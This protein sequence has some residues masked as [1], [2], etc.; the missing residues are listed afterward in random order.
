MLSFTKSQPL[1]TVTYY[2]LTIHSIF[3]IF[4]SLDYSYTFYLSVFITIFKYSTIYAGKS[5]VC[6]I[7]ISISVFHWLPVTIY[8]FITI[9]NFS[10][11]SF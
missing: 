7:D 10:I 4:L 6:M 3:Y 2:N 8:N 11:T 9:I 1:V 5:C